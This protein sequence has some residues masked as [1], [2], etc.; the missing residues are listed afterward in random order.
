MPL[1]EIVDTLIIMFL[2]ILCFGLDRLWDNASLP[3]QDEGK[4]NAIQHVNGCQATDWMLCVASGN[5]QHL[6][7]VGVCDHRNMQVAPVFRREVIG[8]QIMGTPGTDLL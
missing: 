7:R 2:L 1:V 3:K 6:T 4:D 8:S 5:T